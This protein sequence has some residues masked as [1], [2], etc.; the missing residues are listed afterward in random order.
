M[1]QL[2]SNHLRDNDRAKEDGQDIDLPK[3]NQVMQQGSIGDDTHLETQASGG[4]PILFQVLQR[5]VERHLVG[6]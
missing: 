5:I 3:E 4:L 1:V 6:G 2:G